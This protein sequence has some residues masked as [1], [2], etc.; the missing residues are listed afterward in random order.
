M[1]GLRESGSAE[2]STRVGEALDYAGFWIRVVAAVID[3]VLVGIVQGAA[4]FTAYA[5]GFFEMSPRLVGPL[6]VLVSQLVPAAIVTLFWSK[7]G[8]TPGKMAVGAG[9]VDAYTGGRPSVRQFLERYFA[10]YISYLPFGLGCFWVAWDRRKQGWHDKLAG[11]V[12][13]R[14]AASGAGVVRFDAAA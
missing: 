9:V 6:Y 7:W 3:G 1:H 4:F 10:Y 2:G 8:A 14:R 12:V 5:A 11:T 13:V